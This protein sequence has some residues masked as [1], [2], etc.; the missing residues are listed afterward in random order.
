MVRLP[1][2]IAQELRGYEVAPEVL[3]RPPQRQ[4]LVGEDLD[5]LDR[6]AVFTKWL[7]LMCKLCVKKGKWSSFLKL[8][9]WGHKLDSKGC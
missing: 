9:C 4:E 5:A 2:N 1:S 7:R 6:T 3:R 8:P